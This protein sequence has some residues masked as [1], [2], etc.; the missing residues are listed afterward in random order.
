VR[1]AVCR[2]FG[3]PLAIEEL[4]LDRPREREAQVRIAASAICH[5]DISFAEGAWGGELPAVYGHEAAGVVEDVG[6]G[7]TGV[8]SGDRVV[9][10]L[11]R[12]CG[13]CFFC[14]RD[15]PHLCEGVFP[16]DGDVRLR[17]RAG[18]AV[19]QAMHTATFAEAVVV[20][21]SQL[22]VVP[23]SLS[24]EAASVIGCAVV[25]GVGAVTERAGVPAGASVVVIGTGGVGLN[26]V[27]GAALSGADPIVGLDVSAAKREAALRFGATHT[28]D[29]AG[30]AVGA[31]RELTEGR[32]GDFVFVTVGRADAIERGLELVRRGGMLVVVGMPPSDETFR[33]VAVDLAHDD[34]RIVGSKMGSARLD[35]VVPRLVDEYERGRLMLDE[36]ISARY[37]LDRI[38]DAI[39][40]ARA[41]AALRNVVVF[42]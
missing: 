23:D 6:P 24:F 31:V 16:A 42:E 13:S 26:A 39:A 7:T 12:S 3:E 29:A 2:A 38:N 9:V 14:L 17:T 32:G 5:S 28:F 10:S 18:E 40:D 20:H 1:A 19:H 22:A 4:E 25:T 21:E 41:G 11:L 8:T 27:Q 35:E 36:L 37:P 15:E 30:D 33:V 34:I